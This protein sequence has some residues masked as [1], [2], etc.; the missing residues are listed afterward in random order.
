MKGNV[1]KF[2]RQCPFCQKQ[3]Y[4]LPN[5]S[6]DVPSFTVT[7][8]VAMQ[9]I[10]PLHADIHGNR[11]IMIIIDA[12]TRCVMCYALKTLLLMNVQ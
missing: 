11:H 3:D 7:E 8:R 9:H 1:T 10:G 6:S 12:F 5:V 4:T 2:I